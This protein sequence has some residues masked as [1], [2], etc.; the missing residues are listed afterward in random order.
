MCSSCFV[1][2]Y[3]I[4]NKLNLRKEIG[5]TIKSKGVTIKSKETISQLQQTRNTVM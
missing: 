5:V 2:I 1:N 4:Y 3:K